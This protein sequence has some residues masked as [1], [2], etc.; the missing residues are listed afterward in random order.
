MEVEEIED[1]E[2][3]PVLEGSFVEVETDD[4]DQSSS[5]HVCYICEKR[6]QHKH[7]LK[8]HFLVHSEGFVKC[9]FCS[10]SLENKQKLDKYIIRLH[11]GRFI[12]EECGIDYKT[13]QTL[14][15]HRMIK[16]KAEG[17]GRQ[18]CPYPECS[19]VFIKKTIYQDHINKHM[20]NRQF[21]CDK[22][23]KTFISRY[24]RNRH[25]KSCG[26]DVSQSCKI[27]GLSFSNRQNLYNHTTS[28][29]RNRRHL[30]T[31]GKEYKYING[32]MKHKRA[33]KHT[34]IV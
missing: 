15:N 16:H 9:S 22:C 4:I 25:S 32:L 2:E 31:C 21:K 6:F 33:K 14:S 7:N 34:A 3:I 24:E 27:C 11:T 17:K 12:C 13:S 19:R 8:R 18:V 20:N 26:K 23:D 30:C 29:H 28:V 10:C 5:E 1:I